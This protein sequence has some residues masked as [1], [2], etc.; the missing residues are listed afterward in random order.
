MRFGGLLA[1]D[2]V[3]LRVPEGAIV[4]LIGP[5]GA[6]KTTLFNAVTG[7][8][9]ASAGRIELFGQDVAG[10]S[11]HRRAQLGVGRTFQRLELFSSLTVTENLVV[12]HEAVAGRGG[13]AA[14]LLALPSAV[15]TRAEAEAR[16]AKLLDDLGLAEF[17]SSLAGELPAGTSR[18][19]ELARALC[20]N[21]RLLL[22]DEPSSG[23][24]SDETRRLARFLR[25]IRDERGISLLVVEHDM[26]FV[27]GLC[28]YVYVVEFGRLL[29][30]GTPAEIRGDAAV[31]AAYL[32]E[33]AEPTTPPPGRRRRGR[34]VQGAPAT[35]TGAAP[36]RRK[37]RK[38][39][40][41]AGADTE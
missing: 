6:G 2:N 36:D 4:G 16:A 37:A 7:L 14:D 23:L 26:P 1:V 25:R 9:R 31:Q 17:G 27:L 21:P 5:N 19:V 33:E 15:A 30:E 10:W 28:E 11:V 35:A 18:L 20:G 34:R 32:G 29:A 38:T 12:A 39:A 13:L 3:S 41:S 8:V 24:R 40:A 22:L